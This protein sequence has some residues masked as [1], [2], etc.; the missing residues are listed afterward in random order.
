MVEPAPPP[1]AI[2]PFPVDPEV[3]SSIRA[4]RMVDVDRVAELHEA[5]MGNS[6]WAKL[7]TR[8][9]S[10]L[11]RGLINNR[12]FLGFVY[13]EDGRVR[14][15][16]AGSTDAGAMMREVFRASWFLLGPASLPRALRPDVLRHLLTTARYFSA[17]DSVLGGQD[18]PAESL[19]CSF[20]PDLRGKRVSGHINKVL[21]DDLL[22]R[23]VQAVKIT[24]ETDNEGANRQ[25]QSWGFQDRGRFSFYG[26][27][28]VTYVLDLPACPRVE[29]VLRHPTV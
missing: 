28:M 17:S 3:M 24:T 10:Q 26:K 14:G 5:A 25:L 22:A 9:L 6:L 12:R 2:K 16:I 20:E 13:E 7:G 15:F 11:Y 1:A 27:Q 29:P 19:F 23:G 18:V 8:F 4:M 21:F